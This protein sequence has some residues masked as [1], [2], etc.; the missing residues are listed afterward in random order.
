MRSYREAG[1]PIPRDNEIML[2]RSIRRN[3]N[4]PAINKSSSE[5]PPRFIG[6]AYR[7]R[8][9][10]WWALLALLFPRIIPACRIPAA[11]MDVSSRRSQEPLDLIDG[12]SFPERISLNLGVLGGATRCKAPMY[13][14]GVRQDDYPLGSLEATRRQAGRQAGRQRGESSR[15]ERFLVRR[16][17]RIAISASRILL[18]RARPSPSSFK[19]GETH[20]RSA[21]TPEGDSPA[22]STGDRV[23]YFFHFGFFQSTHGRE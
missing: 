15:R 22:R 18:L 16:R 13:P 6:P 1:S 10:S 3:S 7:P 12:I 5:T 19:D 9:F 21:R 14:N 23:F 4:V 8:V 11:S 2:R 20:R 17:R